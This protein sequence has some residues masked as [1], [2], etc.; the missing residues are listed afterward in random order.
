MGAPPH[1]GLP[2]GSD[3]GRR[4]GLAVSGAAERPRTGRAT[5]SHHDEL[6]HRHRALADTWLSI[7]AFPWE[8]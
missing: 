3:R 1:G 2:A 8:A 5:C 4:D 6:G 7:V